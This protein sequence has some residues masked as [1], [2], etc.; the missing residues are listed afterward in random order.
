MNAKNPNEN[1]TSKNACKVSKRL[2]MISSG[3]AIVWDCF[4]IFYILLFSKIST[5][6]NI[7]FVIRKK[8]SVLA[9]MK[10]VSEH[11]KQIPNEPMNIVQLNLLCK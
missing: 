11:W 10:T 5:I 9:S 7:I 1:K 8:L 2:I 6:S 4:F 3:Y